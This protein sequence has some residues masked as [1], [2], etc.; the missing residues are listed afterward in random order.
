MH[1]IN[2][3]SFDGWF[4]VRY[5]VSLLVSRVEYNTAL[6]KLNSSKLLFP[7]VNMTELPQENLFSLVFGFFRARCNVFLFSLRFL[8]EW[9]H[10]RY[11]DIMV[12]LSS[13]TLTN[14]SFLHIALYYSFAYLHLIYARLMEKNGFHI[15]QKMKF[16]VKDFFSNCDQIR[17][18]LWIWSHLL[19]KSLMENFIFC[20]VSP[21]LRWKFSW[22]L[23]QF[24][25]T[26]N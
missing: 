10:L 22:K 3:D 8:Y 20:A 1:H 14:I 19:R 18:F 26:N 5:R 13:K 24:S 23:Q 12:V 16:S 25:L 7:E 2:N 15:A 4:N 11:W 17:S 21:F 9:H 6:P